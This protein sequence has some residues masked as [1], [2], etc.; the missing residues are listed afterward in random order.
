MLSLCLNHLDI[1]KYET[2][3][4]SYET[5]NMMFNYIECHKG[6]ANYHIIFAFLE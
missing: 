1:F 4:Y 5:M 2:S 6:L 3:I